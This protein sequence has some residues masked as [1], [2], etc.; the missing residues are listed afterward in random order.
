MT[1]VIID[2]KDK[3]VLADKQT[4]QMF[5]KGSSKHLNDKSFAIDTND[6][7]HRHDDILL[8]GSGD[9]D[10]ILRLIRIYKN[11]GHI[12]E[13]NLPDVTIA[14]VR[15]KGDGLFIE[16]YNSVKGKHF[17]NSPTWDLKLIQGDD[18]VITF[19]S[20]GDYAMGAIKAGVSSEE[21]MIAAS[22]CDKYTSF[23][24]DVVRL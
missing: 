20:G 21:A 17:W 12:V 14:V 9:R 3:K 24:Y 23:E 22:K 2:F 5:Y 11:R 4:T 19:G 13:P 10:E 6:K 8:T 1:T 18:N 7:I 15:A 16:L